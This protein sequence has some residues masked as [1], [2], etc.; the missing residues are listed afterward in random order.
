MPTANNRKTQPELPLD[1]SVDVFLHDV[2]VTATLTLY[3]VS[4]LPHDGFTL[5]GIFERRYDVEID[6]RNFKVGKAR[7]KPT[8]VAWINVVLFR[9]TLL[10][11]SER[12]LLSYVYRSGAKHS[13]RTI[14]PLAEL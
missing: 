10:P 6:I 1:A 4:T 9:K 3:L 5:A 11:R 12:R 7:N 14:Y 13:L 2:A 8:L